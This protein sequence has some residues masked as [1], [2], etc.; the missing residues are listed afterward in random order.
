MKARTTEEVPPE[1][2][3]LSLGTDLA[4]FDSAEELQTLSKWAK[5]RSTYRR[6]IQCRWMLF[7]RCGHQSHVATKW[8]AAAD[9]AAPLAFIS[10]RNNEV[11]LGRWCSAAPES[12]H[13][14][15]PKD[16]KLL[17]LLQ[18][19]LQVP[20]LA[21]LLQ[22]GSLQHSPACCTKMCPGAPG[23]YL[24]SLTPC[25]HW[26]LCSALW[27]TGT[28]EP[29]HQQQHLLWPTQ[30]GGKPKLWYRGKYLILTQPGKYFLEVAGLVAHVICDPAEWCSD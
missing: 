30:C 16:V 22:A 27:D 14:L 17:I 26:A 15:I 25:W 1:H 3:F 23:G 19:C 5:M 7:P 18:F 24:S 12:S 8:R 10:L 4:K 11:L 6:I 28:T 9:R 2:I 21:C 13:N 29:P 20:Y